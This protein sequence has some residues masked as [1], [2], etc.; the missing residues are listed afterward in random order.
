VC[1]SLIAIKSETADGVAIFAKNSDRP[2][3]EGQFLKFIP[4]EDHPKNSTVKCTYI[5]IPQVRHTNAVLLSKPY[6]IWGAE[7]G[8]NDKY[9]VIGNEAVFPKVP[10]ET[11]T[12]LIGMDLVRLG[13]ERGNTAREA[14]DVMINMLETYGQG[15]SCTTNCEPYYSSFLI[16][17]PD[18]AWVLETAG[19]WYAAKHVTESSD[20]IS[21]YLTIED[22]YVL[23]SPGLAEYAVKQGWAKSVQDF[24]FGDAYNDFWRTTLL[25]GRERRAVTLGAMRARKGTIDVPYMISILRTHAPDGGSGTNWQPQNDSIFGMD[26]CMHSSFGIIRDSNSAGSLV[27]HLDKKNP[28]I[29]VTGTASPCTSVFKPVWMDASLPDIGPAPSDEY[30]PNSQ[31]WQH[32]LVHRATIQDFETRLAAY[33]AE[34]DALEKGFIEGGLNMASTTARKRAK[35]SAEC[36]AQA[37]AAEANW[38]QRIRQIPAHPKGAWIYNYAWNKFNKQ[39]NMPPGL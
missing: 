26:V 38:Y 10:N 25:K 14:L 15:G 23:S 9:V 37:S 39:A 16:A 31:F 4:A 34:R 17:D 27:V 22:D 12:K 6:W 7:M 5:E 18:D 29:F 21:N 20:S 33:V 30:D 28:T 11:N 2:T 32:E 19:S 36:F 8:V 13:L 35:F 24:K 3:N 1:D